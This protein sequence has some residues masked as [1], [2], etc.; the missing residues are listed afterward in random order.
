MD[1]QQA[2]Q[3][4]VHQYITNAIQQRAAFL[5]QS[6]QFSQSMT[7]LKVR[8]PASCGTDSSIDTSQTVNVVDTLASTLY[9]DIA[10]PVHLMQNSV[11][12]GDPSNR[13]GKEHCPEGHV[14]TE[15]RKHNGKA[16]NQHSECIENHGYPR[17]HNESASAIHCY[18]QRM[19]RDHNQ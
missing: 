8:T 18:E 2:L 13:N 9:K 12:A 14:C 15:R 19:S 3:A 5:L 17:N 11:T 7:Y 4:A 10:C 1:A 16:G 6:G